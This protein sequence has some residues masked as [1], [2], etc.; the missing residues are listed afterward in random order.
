MAGGK[1]TWSG[2]Q[3]YLVRFLWLR[4]MAKSEEIV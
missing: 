3:Q 1:L 4:G 2:A